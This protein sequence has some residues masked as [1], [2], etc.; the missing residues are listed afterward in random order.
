MK[1]CIALYQV[2]MADTTRRGPHFFFPEFFKEY[3]SSDNRFRLLFFIRTDNKE[4]LCNEYFTS[5]DDL[6][7]VV[8][9]RNFNNRFKRQLETLE[10]L[11]KLLWYRVRIFQVTALTDTYDPMPAMKIIQSIRPW[12][13]IKMSF[14]VTYNG[15]PTA[16]RQDFTGRYAN[17]RKY[18]T[19]FQSICLDGIYSWYDD[20]VDW[21][22]SSNVLRCKPHMHFIQSRFCDYKRFK[23][24]VKERVI[25]WASALVALKRPMLFLEALKIVH[26]NEGRALEGWKVVLVGTGPLHSE[27]KQFIEDSGLSNLVQLMTG[28]NDLSPLLNSSMC[29]V[30]TQEIENFPSLAMNEALASGNA[31]VA[32]DVGRTHLFVK[33]GQNG[34]LAKEETAQSLASALMAYLE[35]ASRHEQMMNYSRELCQTVHTADNFISEIDV[36]WRELLER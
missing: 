20:F 12:W 28:T 8:F 33:D 16:F 9:L 26:D 17:D 32:F 22:D 7:D 11:L 31:I 13:K 4:R 23:P 15:I 3:K 19:F 14:T 21:A 18:R 27:L 35:G 29:Y 6:R 25:V 24:E 2:I 1:K 34:F 10:L 5:P 36:Y 30:S